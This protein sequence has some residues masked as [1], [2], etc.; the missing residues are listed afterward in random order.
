VNGGI[1]HMLE[2]GAGH[3]PPTTIYNRFVLWAKRGVWE[4]MF[5]EL[6]RRG[7]S[8]ET[9]MINST[10]IKAHRSAA[11]ENG[12]AK[13]GDGTLAWRAQYENTGYR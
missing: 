11:V 9:Q 2:S 13:S 6:S 10:R 12:G 1:L 8:A 3:G 7:R 5:Q 4:R